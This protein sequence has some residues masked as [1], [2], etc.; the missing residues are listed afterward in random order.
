[1]DRRQSDAWLER[2]QHRSQ[3]YPSPQRKWESGQK[4]LL[5]TAGVADLLL[6]SRH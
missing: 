3:L 4:R 5:P 1:M 6:K 2:R